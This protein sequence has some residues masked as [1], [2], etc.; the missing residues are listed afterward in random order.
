VCE[1]RYIVLGFPIPED[2]EILNQV[3]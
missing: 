1:G 2:L 3:L